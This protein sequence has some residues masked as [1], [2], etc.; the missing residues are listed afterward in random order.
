M[1]IVLSR[2]YIHLTSEYSQYLNP[3]TALNSGPVVHSEHV[4]ASLIADLAPG[5]IFW[6]LCR[7]LS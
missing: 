4:C 7:A 1:L 6:Y 2:S 3:F 5:M